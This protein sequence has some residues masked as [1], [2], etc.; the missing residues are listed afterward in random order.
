MGSKW[1]NSINYVVDLA[2]K[3]IWQF[4]QNQLSC[5]SLVVAGIFIA[6]VICKL[7]YLNTARSRIMLLSS[8]SVR[9]KSSLK[10]MK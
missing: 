3:T 10:E 2:V 4:M 7:Q 1:Y 8:S 9:V 5:N 6:S